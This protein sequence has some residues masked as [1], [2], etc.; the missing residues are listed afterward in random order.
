MRKRWALFLC[1][2]ALLVVGCQGPSR[3]AM[4]KEVKESSFRL[5]YKLGLS[6]IQSERYKDALLEL[7]E[8]RRLNPSSPKVYNGLG[9]AYLGLGELEKAQKSFEKAVT[10]D[11]GYS[12][13]HTNLATVYLQR[14]EWEKA[15][16]EC[17]RALDNPLYL[18]PEVAYNNRGYAYQMMGKER[19]ALLDYYRALRYNPKFS[20]AYENLIA[21]YLSKD[22]MVRARGILDD[23][24]ALGLR[25]PGLIFYK[26][27]FSNI[28]GDKEQAC[29]LFQRLVREYPL[30]PWARKAK[31]YIDLMGKCNAQG[32][33]IL[34]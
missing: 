13:A 1:L 25:N 14:R 18:S 15:V 8:A 33:P 26:A 24:V 6:Y 22:D 17:T 23:A 20:K 30:T 34:R 10:L 19:E 2:A 16:E 31:A 5:K 27:L 12:E 32:A 21:Y 29:E 3:V 4:E 9:V 11:P 7:L 28:D